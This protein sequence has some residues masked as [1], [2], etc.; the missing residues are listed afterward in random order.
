VPR[1]RSG[2]N[3]TNSAYVPPEVAMRTAY[4]AQGSCEG[5]R[6]TA[7]RGDSVLQGFLE[8]QSRKLQNGESA[9]LG[10]RAPLAIPQGPNQ[11]GA[12]TSPPMRSPTAGA[13]VVVDEFTRECLTL[14]ADT[15]LGGVRVARAR[16]DHCST[17]AVMIVRRIPQCPTSP[18][19]LDRVVRCNVHDPIKTVRHTP[20][21]HGGLRAH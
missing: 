21:C 17:W 15:S 1:I 20:S 5:T 6:T 7:G 4:R 8:H 16:R 19:R 3:A 2:P 18:E 9:A 13:L 11:R 10:M 14:V 12:S